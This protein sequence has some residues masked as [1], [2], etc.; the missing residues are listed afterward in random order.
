MANYLYI[1]ANNNIEKDIEEKFF[2]SGAPDTLDKSKKTHN[3]VVEYYISNQATDHIYGDS[4]I[5]QGYCINYNDKTIHYSAPDSDED[6]Q[7]GLEGCYFSAQ[8]TGTKISI[9]NDYFSQLPIFFFANKNCFACSDSLYVLLK[10]RKSLGLSV[11]PD[12]QSIKSRAWI[13]SI[14]NQLISDK[15]PFAAIKYLP[16]LNHIEIN[17]IDGNPNAKIV[18]H[19]QPAKNA[20]PDF[21]A[22][23]RSSAINIRSVVSSLINLYPLSLSLSGG[24]D[25]RVMLASAIQKISSKNLHIGTSETLKRDFEVVNLLSKKFNF[26]FN[27][28][29]NFVSVKTTTVD[30]LSTYVLLS[31]GVY[32]SIYCPKRVPAKSFP[33]PVTGHGAELYKGNY[34]LQS[35]DEIAAHCPINKDLFTL[36]IERGQEKLHV[37]SSSGEVHY[38]GYRN[39]LHGARSTIFSL[40]AIRP[41]MQKSLAEHFMLPDTEISLSE[42]KNIVHDLLI[43][44]SPELASVEF[45][46][47]EKNVSGDYIS[48]RLN[49][50]GGPIRDD[51]LIEFTII[52]T[53]QE[54]GHSISSFFHK[55]TANE[56]YTGSLDST[57]LNRLVNLSLDHGNSELTSEISYWKNHI[58]EINDL[59]RKESHNIAI[60]KILAASILLDNE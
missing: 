46:K 16:P 21:N 27:S 5:F 59:P 37:Q 45:D 36:E 17:I 48:E 44:L 19:A 34:G 7:F 42:R 20:T 55:M 3:N 35:I 43:L 2:S 52:G 8:R 28:R 9:C 47:A 13:N 40:Y 32:D 53:P 57:T 26:T 39:A 41:L 23:T 50:L 1:V 38:L 56:G 25:S 51:E 29:E 4:R 14:T 22:S 30:Q 33:L 24:L 31:C 60:G 54:S 15:T 58:G 10:L 12:I 49:I 18:A 11:H 6:L